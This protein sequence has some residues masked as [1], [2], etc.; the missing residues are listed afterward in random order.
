[1]KRGQIQKSQKKTIQQPRE[2]EHQNA[3]NQT[4]WTL[5]IEIDDVVSLQFHYSTQFS[6]QTWQDNKKSP[7][8]EDASRADEEQGRFQIHLK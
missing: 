5:S 2:W 7:M 1:M 4:V 6:D 8:A 3:R